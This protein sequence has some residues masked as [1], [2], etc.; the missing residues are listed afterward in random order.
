MN[1]SSQ[2]STHN[3]GGVAGKSASPSVIYTSSSGPQMDLPVQ[4]DHTEAQ[5]NAQREPGGGGRTCTT[6]SAAWG[7][8]SPSRPCHGDT[9]PASGPSDRALALNAFVLIVV[10]HTSEVC[11]TALDEEALT[12]CFSKLSTESKLQSAGGRVFLTVH[13]RL[14]HYSHLYLHTIN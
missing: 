12:R 14:P 4:N 5:P 7:T 8:Q 6:G 3:W 10:T 11:P 9:V 2:L 1:T 13:H